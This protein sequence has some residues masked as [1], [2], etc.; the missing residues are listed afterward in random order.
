MC[1]IHESTPILSTFSHSSL[2]F[3]FVEVLLKGGPFHVGVYYRPPSSSN[4]LTDLEDCLLS[5]SPN[6]LKSSV[7]NLLVILVSISYL[8][9]LSQ[10]TLLSLLSQVIP[11]ISYTQSL[12]VNLH[13]VVQLVD[14]STPSIQMNTW[15]QT[16]TLS[17]LLAKALFQ[18][19][20]NFSLLS[21]LRTLTLNYQAPPLSYQ[22]SP[23]S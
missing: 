20:S 3:L 13:H 16:S 18:P 5:I 1:Y 14:T 6:Q 17:G 2:E 4:S 9:L 11:P 15:Q 7:F 23:L 8:T 21:T 10:V 19:A 22:A 12:P